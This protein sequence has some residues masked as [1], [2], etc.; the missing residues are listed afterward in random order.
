MTWGTHQPTYLPTYILISVCPHRDPR[1]DII[2]SKNLIM[3]TR[4]SDVDIT[5]IKMSVGWLV[6]WSRF[7]NL[8]TTPI[9][10]KK[11]LEVTKEI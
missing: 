7:R 5:E 10:T 9:V 6:G 11:K 4:D 1:V 2:N 3:S 8:H